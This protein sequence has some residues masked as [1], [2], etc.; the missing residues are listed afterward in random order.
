MKIHIGDGKGWTFDYE[1]EPMPKERFDALIGVA[2]TLIVCAAAI[3]FF[4]LLFASAS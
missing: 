3:A 1:S 4:A 2:V